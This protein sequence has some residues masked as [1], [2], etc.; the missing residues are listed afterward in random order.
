MTQ[1]SYNPTTLGARLNKRRNQP[2]NLMFNSR[3]IL[4]PLV[5]TLTAATGCSAHATIP[6]PATDAPLAPHSGK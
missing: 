3:T 5:L 6:A 2:G 4:L 1:I